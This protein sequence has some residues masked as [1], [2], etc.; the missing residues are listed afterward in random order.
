MRFR[1]LGHDVSKIPPR[2]HRALGG[3]QVEVAQA[4]HPAL[5]QAVGTEKKDFPPQR[6]PSSSAGGSHF[7]YDL[8]K[9]KEHDILRFE[10]L[11][12]RPKERQPFGQAGPRSPVMD[13]TPLLPARSNL[14]RVAAGSSLRASSRPPPMQ[15]VAASVH[16]CLA[17]ADAAQPSY[18]WAILFPATEQTGQDGRYRRNVRWT[19]QAGTHAITTGESTPASNRSEMTYWLQSTVCPYSI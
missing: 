9:I 4:T 6:P 2:H 15:A 5:L 7:G 10:G 16:L 11:A 8:A 13:T 19:A 18:S 1:V 12:P 17:D 3:L 14:A